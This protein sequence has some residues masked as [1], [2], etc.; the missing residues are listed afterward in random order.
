MAMSGHLYAPAD[1]PPIPREE[2]SRL[3]IPTA[4]LGVVANKEKIPLPPDNGTP[5]TLIVT[6]CFGCS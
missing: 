1:Y 2:S 3:V 4:G 5:I 6:S